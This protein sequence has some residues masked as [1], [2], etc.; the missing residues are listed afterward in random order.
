MVY[1]CNKENLKLFNKDMIHR[2]Q[3]A[4]LILSILYLILLSSAFMFMLYGSSDLRSIAA[5][6]LFV[7]SLISCVSQIINIVSNVLSMCNVRRERINRK[8]TKYKSNEVEQLIIAFGFTSESVAF[9]GI[10]AILCI[11]GIHLKPYD[12]IAPYLRVFSLVASVFSIT[13]GSV[14]LKK[15]IQDHAASKNHKI[16]AKWVIGNSILFVLLAVYNILYETVLYECL[17]FYSNHYLSM[18]L[19][20]FVFIGYSC[21]LTSIFL[22]QILAPHTHSV[23]MPEKSMKGEGKEPQEELTDL[24]AALVDSQRHLE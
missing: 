6:L 9:L 13:Y 14:F 15:S 5:M 1:K 16:H 24:T 18:F 10:A 20:S 8:D 3:R 4:Y 17:D 19:K 23:P 22:S 2:G 12:V 21:V 11:L 7:V